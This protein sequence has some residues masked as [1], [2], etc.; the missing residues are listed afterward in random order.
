MNRIVTTLGGAVVLC[1]TLCPAAG[2]SG[3]SSLRIGATAQTACHVQIF[4]G[5][6]ISSCFPVMHEEF[7]WVNYVDYDGDDVGDGHGSLATQLGVITK[8]PYLDFQQSST[9][10]DRVTYHDELD[11]VPCGTT[12]DPQYNGHGNGLIESDALNAN[13]GEFYSWTGAV[14]DQE[15]YWDVGLDRITGTVSNC[16]GDQINTAWVPGLHAHNGAACTRDPHCPG[17]N[18][19]YGT[20]SSTG[21][22]ATGLHD[23]WDFTC[24]WKFS[25]GLTAFTSTGGFTMTENPCPRVRTGKG[26]AELNNATKARL[27]EYYNILDKA[28]ACYKFIVGYR[29]Q[30]E[31]DKL[32]HDWH[33]IADKQGPGDHRTVATIDAELKAAGFAQM[34]SRRDANGI[35]KGGPAKVSRH[36][37]MQA[38]DISVGFRPVGLFNGAA[39]AKVR[40]TFNPVVHRLAHQADLCGPPVSDPVHVEMKYIKGDETEPTCHFG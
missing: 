2:V 22:L 27:A 24:D 12:A 19:W 28:G 7:A 25:T 14:P 34:Y 31:Q 23:K 33:A 35:A 5:Y 8:N 9:L 1:S 36:T 40:T 3:A 37:S 13:E 16:S 18:I 32:Y 4:H 17:G 29:S 38:A 21:T 15:A 39:M 6:F 10:H 26:Y 30:Q 11:A 20:Y